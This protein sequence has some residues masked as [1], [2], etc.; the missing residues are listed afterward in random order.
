MDIIKLYET[1]KQNGVNT[2]SSINKAYSYLSAERKSK[3]LPLTPFL[4]MYAISGLGKKILK[5]VGKTITAGVIGA[6][7]VECE[8]WNKFL[9]KVYL[10]YKVENL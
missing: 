2:K 7:I 6:V 9:I 8:V 5:T 4:V 3:Y 10:G 1:K